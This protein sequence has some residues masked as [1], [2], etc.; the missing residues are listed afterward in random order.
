MNIDSKFKGEMK[1]PRLDSL[2]ALIFSILSFFHLRISINKSPSDI[3]TIISDYDFN[4]RRLNIKDLKEVIDVIPKSL[5]L[6]MKFHDL[7]LKELRPHVTERSPF[8]LFKISN[9]GE[10]EKA[11]ALDGYTGLSYNIVNLETN[12]KFSIPEAELIS[13]LEI[14]SISQKIKILG[15]EPL[16]SFLNPKPPEKKIDRFVSAI[17]QIV[18]LIKLER[19]DIWIITIYGI[20]IGILSLV[21]P[22]S[23]SALVNVVTFGVLLQPVIVLTLIVVCIM[24]FAGLMQV[25]QTFV[26]EI[27]QR[28]IFVRIALEFSSKFPYMGRDGLLLEHKPELANRFFDSISIQ[29]S[30]NLLLV[31]GLAVILTAIIGLTLIATYHPL[32]LLFDVFILF[33]GAYLIIYKKGIKI[34]YEYLDVSKE[35][36]KVAAWIEEIARHDALFHSKIGKTFANEKMDSLMKDYLWI[37]DSFFQKYIRQII[38]LVSVQTLAS[39]ILLGIGGYLVIQRQLTIGQLVAAEIVISKVLNDMSKFGKHLESFYSLVASIDKVSTVLNYAVIETSNKA[40]VENGSN[41]ALSFENLSYKNSLGKVIFEKQSF[42]LPDKSVIGLNSEFTDRV[43][44]LFYILTGQVSAN[45]GKIYIDGQDILNSDYFLHHNEIY[46]ARGNEIVSG[47]ILENLRLG[48]KNVSQLEIM[49]MIEKLGALEI[50]QNLPDGLKT[51]L[52]TFGFPLSQMEKSLLQLMRILLHKPKI[53][54]IDKIL[55]Q[56]PESYVNS[57]LNCIR[58]EEAIHITIIHSHNRTVISKM[59]KILSLDEIHSTKNL[60]KQGKNRNV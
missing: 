37:R 52:A 24:G 38:G 30:I 14:K 59:D 28:R 11:F 49:R 20:G 58:A 57:F 13:L 7:N 33:L 18:Y 8:I 45:E 53:V 23:T 16:S 54:L 43:D 1:Y 35:K 9:T 51:R 41:S 3:I 15:A 19:N 29:K 12:E 55:D 21:I 60:I 46:L 36:Y 6:H 56:L 10:I 26:I 42:S 2:E 44:A 27:L 17:R 40:F 48:S 5:Q 32:F 50:I 31:D 4:A 47:D 39:G 34:A 22:V 25:V